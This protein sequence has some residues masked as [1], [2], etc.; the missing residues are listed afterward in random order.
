MTRIGRPGAT[1][2][3]ALDPAP[4]SAKMDLILGAY[5]DRGACAGI[6]GPARWNAYERLL[7]ESDHD[8]YAWI[9]G[10]ARAPRPRPSCRLVDDIAAGR[11]RITRPGTTR[12]KI[13]PV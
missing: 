4:A 8:L 1:A 7:D 9:S 10:Q 11:Q 2:L 12:K 5:A 6:G 3:H 13:Q